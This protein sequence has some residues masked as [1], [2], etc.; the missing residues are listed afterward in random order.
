MKATKKY[1]D[2]SDESSG[3][4]FD[5]DEDPDKTEVP[6][7]GKDL[8]TAAGIASI[9]DEKPPTVAP[10]APL[11]KGQG[12][13]SVLNQKFAGK[14]PGGLVTKTPT[15][16]YEMVRVGG[17]QGVAPGFATQN[18]MNQLGQFGGAMPYGFPQSLAS[19]TGFNPAAFLQQTME[20]GNIMGGF[21]GMAGMNMGINPF[22]QLLNQ[23]G[24]PP[25]WA[26]GLSGKNLSQL[27]MNAGD[28][29]KMNM[30][31]TLPEEED[32]EDEEMGVAETYA[33]YMPT[34]LKLGR[35][36]PDPVVE[37]AS[38]SSV[39]PTDVWYKLSIPDETIRSGA[40][41]ALQLESITY[42]SQQHEHLLPD[43]TRAGF[44][45]GDGAGV[46][47]GRT[48]AGI[49]YENY[50]KGRKRAIWVSVSNDLKYDAERDLKDI[51]ATK[52]D[53]HPLNKFKYAKISS[54]VN[55]NVKKGVIFSTY[56]ALIGESS[57]SGGKYKSRLKQLMQWC[58]DDFDG[59]IVFDECHRAKNLCPTGSSKPTKTGLTVLELQNKLPKARVVYASATGASEPRNMAYMVR[60]GMWG[61]GTPF[62]E[63]TDFIAAVEKRG[64]GAMEIVAMDMKLRGMYIA[65]QLS[66]HGVAFK[67]EEVP[68]SKEFAKVYDHSV[69]LWVDAMQ[70][71]QE[72]AELIDAENRM[73]KTMWGQF[74]SSHQRFFKYL[75]IAAKVKHAV[76]VAR[77]AVK[78][79]KCVVIGLQSTGEART[80]EQL[81][82]DDGEL[83]DFVSTAKGVLQTLVEKHFPA[84]DRNRIHRLLGLEPPK[85][86]DACLDDCTIVASGSKRK[87][88]RQAAQRA[89]KKVRTWS[90]EEEISEEDKN[91]GHHSSGSEFKLSGSD[92]EEDRRTDEESNASSDFN[93]FYSDSDSD[94][95]PWDRRKKKGG[96]KQKKPAKK[97][98]ST[99]DKIQSMLAH[100]TSA[101]RNSKRNGDAN[102]G[103]LGNQGINM[104]GR[105]QPSVAPPP[106]DAIER[107]CCMKEEL[108]A[109]I[110][111]LGERLP[112]NTL[113]QLIDELGGPEN[114][115]EMTGR[116]G[117]V[118]QNEDG[119]IQYESR[120][121]VDVPLETLNLTE[122]QRFMDGEKTV[123]IISE[124]ASSGI[125]LQSDR[126]ARN[127]MRRVHITLELPWSADRAIQQFGRT[128]RSNQ[129]NA[130]EYI[131]LISDLAGERRFASIVA[132]R[133]ESLGALTHG[134]R[135]ATETRDLSQFNIDNKYGRS[136]LEATMKTIMGYEAPLV[137]PPQ[138][139]NGDFFKDVADALVGVGLICNSEN[140]PGVLT[141]DKDYNNMSKFL[142]R[143][144]G[145]PV[146]LQNRL[147]KYFTDTL[148]AII[149]QA[150]KTGRFDMGILDLGTS[151]ENVR[152]V[153]IYRFTRK[154]ATGTAPTELHVVHVERGMSWT[155][156]MERFAE[157]TGAKEG[158]YLSHQ[159]RNGKQTAILA[160]A[161]EGGKKKSEGKKDQLYMVYRPNTGLQMRQEALG[162]LEKKYKKVSSEEAESHWTQ[163]Y[164]ASVDTCSHAY[165]RGNCKNVTLGMDCEVGLRRRSYNVLAGSVLSVWSRVESVLTARS[166]HNSKM[167]V[168]RLRT[169]DGLKIVGTLIPKSCMETLREALS[170]DAEKTE[171]QT[172]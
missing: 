28:P 104:G 124:A 148:N 19:L 49:I 6:G 95:D 84:P 80:L 117:R 2:M 152:R 40:L 162:E 121:E 54:A 65:R 138:D 160:V 39:E 33:D 88:V 101:S 144:L 73:K 146:D 37:T 44:L 119:G 55:G 159:V 133:L 23:S 167:Q 96:K 29:G 139:Y 112:P 8:A 89:S 74:W 9:K 47:K 68:L 75:C 103:Q 130:P 128:H 53:V 102:M 140:M 137:P 46:G 171:E 60:L 43:G 105:N 61:E 20:M 122:K 78:C 127:Q 99:Q 110:E 3:S 155:E 106:R 51:G 98:L 58:G 163:Q 129:V 86:A 31:P 5:D 34:K 142:N 161:V 92:T 147:F 56:S 156:A 32:G 36:H 48:I 116:K 72:A 12:G 157:I 94:A 59:L 131:F 66:F 134:D 141:L 22:V 45:I 168:I 14:I 62:P 125:S 154:H 172:F 113:D 69:R 165:W 115:A 16:G 132:K 27:W 77:E 143:I 13:V 151:G 10:A 26:A 82:R 108:L 135:R 83:S 17:S 97:R 1:K 35:K 153:K 64:V 50:L 42:A 67:I 87:P 164:D 63:F 25:N 24:L 109:Q 150:K 79:G 136:A 107:A 11:V 38:L 169:D 118:V 126:R 111:A 91:G 158:F 85:P 21:M 4:D 71:F 166:G 18:Q 145:M 100:K 15:P 57:Q 170:T 149:T 30:Q 114:V 52:V 120:S 76:T 93:P 90:S 123:A 7:G 81:E 41:S 70:R